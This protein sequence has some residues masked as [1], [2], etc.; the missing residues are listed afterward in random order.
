MTGE[1]TQLV[2][3]ETRLCGEPVRLLPERAAYLPQHGALLV[4]D[5]HWGKSGSMRASGVPIPMGTQDEQLARLDS[6]VDRTGASRVIVLGDLF[7]APAGV[8]D[9]FVERLGRRLRRIAARFELVPGNHDLK[10]G[11]RRL[12][13]VCR[14][15]GFELL[16][17][18]IRVGGLTLKHEPGKRGEEAEGGYVVCG[19][20]HPAVVLRGGGDELKLPAFHVGSARFVLPAFSGFAA[21]VSVRAE[22]GEH[23]F[24]IA[25]DQVVAL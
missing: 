14:R 5:T 9:E 24:A 17:A 19:H 18:E 12:G 23:L 15:L 1:A 22:G 25:G 10:L 20:V 6:A 8:G 11:V 21:G 2:D 3:V 4:A 13:E 7:H 16:P